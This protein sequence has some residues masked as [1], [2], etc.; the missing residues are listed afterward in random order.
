MENTA[1]TIKP[2][3]LRSTLTVSVRRKA[4]LGLPGD[5]SSLY[6]IK[7]GSSLRGKGPLRGLDP[8][9]EKLYLPDILGV[10]PSDV[11]W[12]K[13]VSDYWHSISEPVPA[14]QK[15]VADDAVQGRMMTFTVK[16]A[17]KADKEAFESTPSLEEK[18]RLSSYENGAEIVDGIEDYVLFRYC[19]VY[20]RVANQMADV[21]KSAKIRFYLF[22]KENEN[23]LK[24]ATMKLRGQAMTIFYSYLDPEKEKS[25][26]ALL[27]MFGHNVTSLKELN[28]K[29]LKLEEYAQKEPKRFIDYHTDANLGIKANIKKAVEMGIIRSPSLSDAYY[30]GDNDAVCLGT[31]LEDAV[32]YF[33]S[34]EQK[35]KDI[36]ATIVAKMK[37][38]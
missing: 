32:L 8:E 3:D 38:H 19:L 15:D 21:K 22:S 37:Q 26:E 16:F 28:E 24:H 36:V 18:G 7:I 14:D 5:D 25:V 12:R 17:S 20:G 13:N 9:E 6:N 11:H 31:S 29:H 1:Q 2:K 23:K 4:G 30:Y 34:T 10:D 27:R 33:K 35:N